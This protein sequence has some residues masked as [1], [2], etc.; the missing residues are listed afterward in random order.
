MI[1]WPIY[2]KVMMVTVKK[3]TSTHDLRKMLVLFIVYRLLLGHHSEKI[4]NPSPKRSLS[5]LKQLSIAS[6]VFHASA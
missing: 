5:F 2:I 6:T 3:V 4:Y 1:A